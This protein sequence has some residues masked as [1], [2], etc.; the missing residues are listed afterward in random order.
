MLVALFAFASL[1]TAETLQ[2]T[3]K[4]G[5]TGKPA[6]GV[7]VV[8]LSLAQGMKE[9][10]RTTSD[11]SGRFTFTLPDSGGPHLVRITHQG[12]NYFG[13]A[14]P[15][16]SSVDVQVYEAAK[17]VEGISTPVKI[18][19]FEAQGDTL[20]VLE[21]Y[22]VNNK[23]TPPRTLMA[24]RTFEIVLPEGAQIDD[25]TA[26]GPGGQP[27]KSAPVPVDEGKGHYY[28]VFP[29]RPGETRFQVAYH[30]P[31][32][33]RMAF[34][35]SVLSRLEHFVAVLPRYMQF[36][37]DN[38]RLF[39]SMPDEQGSN[40]QVVTGVKPGD[41]IGFTLAGTGTLPAEDEQAQAQGAVPNQ[42][43]NMGPGGGLG[44]PIDAPDPLS[45]YR[46]YIL[47]GFAVLL[48][49]GV[50]YTV[51]RRESSVQV[52]GAPGPEENETEVQRTNVAAAA[53]NGGVK[54]SALLLEA[55]KEELFQLEVD[56]QRQKI[57][58]AE[59]EKAKAALGETIKRTLARSGSE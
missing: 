3:V 55:M 32:S 31:Y 21:L 25:S 20:N 29:L 38:S 49:M 26:Q 7:N 33:G 27:V 9:T 36:T 41:A 57:S 39:Q 48:A 51:S 50:F 5:T 37:P 4:N 58:A 53:V 23:S 59:Y 8:L 19:R 44:P 28:F 18:M 43:G 35:P 46:W 15:G 52:T 16:T 2:G 6:A 22:A 13:M 34:K 1:A 30:L 14:P 40:I 42:G 11:G 47:G 24:D 12:V 17:K 56:R 10:G 54:R 45:R